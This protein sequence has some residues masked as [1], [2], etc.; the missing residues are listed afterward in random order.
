MVC[1]AARFVH[2]RC[3]HNH[4][5]VVIMRGFSVHQALCT[6]SGLTANHANCLQLVHVLSNGHENWHTAKWFSPKISI[7][8][9]NNHPDSPIGQRFCY[10]DNSVIKELGFIDTHHRSIFIQAFQ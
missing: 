7:Q 9:G 6:A 4:D 5:R 2:L 10:S 3:T 1:P 8:A